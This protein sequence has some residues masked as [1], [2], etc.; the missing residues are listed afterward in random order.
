MKLQGGDL[1][2]WVSFRCLQCSC[3]SLI[4]A[5]VIGFLCCWGVG[6]ISLRGMPSC[7]WERCRSTGQG[8]HA[9]FLPKMWPIF[10]GRKLTGLKPI[11]SQCFILC[12]PYLCV[13][14]CGNLYA[15]WKPFFVLLCVV[16]LCVV[17]AGVTQPTKN[18][19]P[20]YLLLSCALLLLQG[21]AYLSVNFT[22]TLV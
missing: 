1:R 20:F 22:L 13:L 8:V 9:N 21:Y 3:F 15:E 11:D 7:F 14:F 17:R 18:K 19:R 16:L 5:F 6:V 10:Y 4:A 2:K 12:L